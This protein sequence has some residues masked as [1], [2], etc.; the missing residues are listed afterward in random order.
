MPADD[1]E[2][3]PRGAPSYAVPSLKHMVIK[4]IMLNLI[5]L[6]FRD[7]TQVTRDLKRAAAFMALRQPFLSPLIS[8]TQLSSPLVSSRPVSISFPFLGLNFKFMPTSLT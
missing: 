2:F 5:K 7:E 4:M 3:L 6:E 1:L 8:P